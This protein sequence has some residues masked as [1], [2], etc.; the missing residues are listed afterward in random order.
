MM[1]HIPQE[2]AEELLNTA[3]KKVVAGAK[4]KNVAKQ[5]NEPNNTTSQINP[6]IAKAAALKKVRA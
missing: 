4:T 5:N 3:L 1:N 2:V 6:H